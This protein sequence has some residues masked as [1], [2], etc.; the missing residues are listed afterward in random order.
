MACGTTVFGPSS[1]YIKIT[2]GDF[3]AIQGSNTVEKF[4]TND[5]QIPYSQIMRST[6]ILKA[7]QANYLLNNLGLGNNAT[8]LLLRA[9]YDSGSVIEEDNYLQYNYYDDLTKSYYM[10]QLL[11]LT[12]NSTNRVKQIYLTNPNPDYAVTVSVMAASIDDTYSP[13]TDTVNQSG[14]S[15]TGLQYTDIQSFVVGQ[16]IVIYDKSTPPLPLIYITLSNINSIQISGTILIV[17]DSSVGTIFLQFLTVYDADQ[18]YSLLNYVINNPNVNIASLN[19]VADLV[20]PVVYFWSNVGNTQSGSYIEFNGMTAGVPYDT[21]YG[22]TFST[23][24]SLSQFG[25]SAS[26][27]D[28]NLLSTL[29]INNVV[30]NRDGV[31]NII[32]SENLLIYSGTGT[33]SGVTSSIT[34]TGSY[35]LGFNLSDIAKN[36]VNGFVNLNI[37]S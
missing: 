14:T 28:Q 5:L 12:G 18:A 7:G 11:L 21:S 26:V 17:N 16:S 34:A 13:F 10:A 30:D 36:Y 6:V 22:M 3:V 2:G 4:I 32:P 9:T 37:V 35:T 24:I 19:P 29:L 1:Q 33:M 27:I 25:S 23:T 15:F 31:I 20:A 8:F